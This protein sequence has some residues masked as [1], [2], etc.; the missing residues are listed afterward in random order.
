MKKLLRVLLSVTST[1]A[2]TLSIV[3]CEQTNNTEK[4]ELEMQ[5][6]S[7]DLKTDL[8]Q[9]DVASMIINQQSAALEEFLSQFLKRNNA[10]NDFQFYFASGNDA[11]SNEFITLAELFE[12][13]IILKVNLVLFKDYDQYVNF[14]LF[15]VRKNLSELDTIVKLPKN[16]YLDRNNVINPDIYSITK[17]AFVE[18]IGEIVS[19]I[20]EPGVA[21]FLQTA[22]HVSKV[23]LKNYLMNTLT[24]NVM[25]LS[26]AEDIVLGEDNRANLVISQL[27]TTSNWF[28]NSFFKMDGFSDGSANS[29]IV[30]YE[31]IVINNDVT[32]RL[33]TVYKLGQGDKEY[34]LENDMSLDLSRLD[35]TDKKLGDIMPYIKT[36]VKTWI[37]KEFPN[38]NIDLTEADFE[39]KILK[40]LSPTSGK[41]DE[42]VDYWNSVENIWQ[43]NA[44]PTGIT[45]G[46]YFGESRNIFNVTIMSSNRDY[47]SVFNDGATRKLCA[48]HLPII[49]NN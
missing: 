26:I 23:D 48:F 40:A 11:Q 6:L 27:E 37:L 18:L 5:K 29:Q 42:W 19:K 1:V 2:P 32:Q 35:L 14:E 34:D 47:L 15:D 39:I 46:N 41:E 43:D 4:L 25:Y 20:E 8:S 31:K 36:Y 17:S 33:E 38:N 16:F 9:I 21:E 44:N 3:A 24:N 30:L 49:F 45:K 10:E 13:G 7:S 12:L 28:L 22:L